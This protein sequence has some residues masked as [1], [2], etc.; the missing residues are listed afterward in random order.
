MEIE[1]AHS[2]SCS[3]CYS[4]PASAAADTFDS[5]SWVGGVSMVVA[6]DSTGSG[7]YW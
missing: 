5:M 2:G 7:A 6:F 3:R 4:V 1:L